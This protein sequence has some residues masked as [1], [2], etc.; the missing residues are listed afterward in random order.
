M[1]EQQDLSEI[2]DTDEYKIL[3]LKLKDFSPKYRVKSYTLWY[4][5]TEESR[6]N[7]YQV[8]T[9]NAKTKIIIQYGKKPSTIYNKTLSTVQ[10]KILHRTIEKVLKNNQPEVTKSF[11]DMQKAQEMS[12]VIFPMIKNTFFHKKMTVAWNGFSI[13]FSTSP[14]ETEYFTI[15]MN[16]KNQF[17]F[18]GF[19]ETFGFDIVYLNKILD[20]ME[21]H[22]KTNT[23][24]KKLS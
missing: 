7:I 11:S 6:V 14:E 22:Y 1:S 12:G 3:Y 16:L 24:I 19:C 18:S 13:K 5:V 10:P 8:C 15:Y 20:D 17:S 4:E 21:K 23:I 2:S 9:K